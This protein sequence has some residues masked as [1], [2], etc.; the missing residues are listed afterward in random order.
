MVEPSPET[1][2]DLAPWYDELLQRGSGPHETALT[3]LLALIPPSSTG[4]VLDVGCGQGLATRELA[5]R[6]LRP[7]VGIDAAEPMLTIACERT[8]PEV[9]I[10]WRVDDAERLSSCATGCFAGVT[11]QLALMDIADRGSALGSIRRVLEPGGWFV[12][13]IGHPCFLAPHASKLHWGLIN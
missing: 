2:S 9:E 11:C 5:A 3:A 4:P 12:F 8:S 6:G 7:V 13:V 10:E 1:W